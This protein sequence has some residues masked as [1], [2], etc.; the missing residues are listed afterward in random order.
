M[1]VMTMIGRVIDG[2]PLAASMQ[3]DQDVSGQLSIRTYH[4]PAIVKL[5]Y[6]FRRMTKLGPI[7]ILKNGVTKSVSEY[8]VNVFLVSAHLRRHLFIRI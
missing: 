8:D 6:F 5:F 4:R 1:V 3:S 7:H 2:L